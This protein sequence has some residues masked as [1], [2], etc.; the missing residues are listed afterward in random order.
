MKIYYIKILIL[1]ILISCSYSIYSQNLSQILKEDFNKRE[2]LLIQNEVRKKLGSRANKKDVN[3]LISDLLPWAIMEGQ[4]SKSF[5]RTI[6]LFTRNIDA[7][8][9]ITDSEDL[10]PL[11]NKYNGTDDDFLFLSKFYQEA[12]TA[13]LPIEVRDSYIRKARE[14][15]INGFST[16]IG[17]RILIFGLVEK[18]DY[19]K[20]F[21]N[22]LNKL[23]KNIKNNSESKNK[24][25][26]SE[27]MQSFSEERKDSNITILMNQLKDTQSKTG[28][29]LTNVLSKKDRNLESSF[30]EIGE[31]DFKLRPKIELSLEDLG[32]EPAN[33]DQS[34]STTTNP[35]NTNTPDTSTIESNSIIP[36]S[37]WK[38]LK[39]KNLIHVVDGWLGTKYVY[40]GGTKKGT[41]CSG[42]T[43]GVFTDPLIS[44]PRS[45]LPRTARHQA[46]V[47]TS[48]T[49]AGIKAGDLVFFSASKN[50][51]K[52]TH[53]GLALGGGQFSHASS[54]RGVVIQGLS[55]KWWVDRFVT[56][57]RL[58]SKVD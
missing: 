34:N 33:S 38:N 57:R 31:L 25:L 37:N 3:L 21:H 36:P 18:I 14:K 48:V 10:I 52:I 28:R 6:V 43:L 4:D 39:K 9:D 29:S 8:I 22:V 24:K 41:D 26:F 44:V 47:G 40:G 15:N 12:N 11:L 45:E 53:V 49:R 17:G 20:L 16:W 19:N 7:G 51:T 35:N 30:S 5:A 50:Q 23:P 2:Q 32:I 1:S 58:F 54:T 42:F 56:S 13:N 27:L 55:E 46:Q